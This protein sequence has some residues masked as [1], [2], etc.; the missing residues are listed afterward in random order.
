VSKADKI[1]DKVMS[2]TADVNLPY[3][4]LCSLLERLGFVSRQRGTSHRTFKYGSAFI[5]V[6]P[7][8]AGKA[9]PYQVRQVRGALKKL[10]IRP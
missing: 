9:K 8:S 10:N 1:F 6:Q 3:D 2:G 4:D 5:N 7:G